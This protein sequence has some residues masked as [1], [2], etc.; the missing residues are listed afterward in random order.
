MGGVEELK[1]NYYVGKERE[2]AKEEECE[3]A[4]E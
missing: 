3:Q 1:K 2:G 4:S